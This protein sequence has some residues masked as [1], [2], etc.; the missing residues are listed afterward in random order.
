MGTVSRA[1]PGYIPPT[2]WLLGQMVAPWSGHPCLETEAGSCATPA[3]GGV[4]GWAE[5]VRTMAAPSPVAQVLNEATGSLELI[6][7]D[8]T[9]SPPVTLCEALSWADTV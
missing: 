5:G 4:Q 8:Y 9:M 7:L 6:G 1:V 2:P 3:R